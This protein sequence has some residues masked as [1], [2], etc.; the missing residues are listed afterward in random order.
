MGNK[1]FGIIIAI[2]IGAVIALLVFGGTSE[3]PSNNESE[4]D[5]L[6]IT[7]S[8]HVKNNNREGQVTIIEYADFQCPACAQYYPIVEQVLSQYQDDQ[9][10]FAFRHF[11]LVN[12]H[13]NAM[14]AHRAAEAAGEQDKF[15]EMYDLLF[16]R[17]TQWSEASN[18]Q[19][20]IDG[21]AQE[22]EL[23]MDRYSAT[24]NSSDTLSFINSQLDA[25]QS[26]GVAS[27]PTF[28]VDGE[29]LEQNPRSVEEFTALID[30][31]LAE[32]SSDNT[33]N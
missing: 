1:T 13:P 9:V 25:G 22:L 12:I 23:D 26:I 16:Q 30:Q 7:E 4:G 11:P 3:A 32:D 2:I 27:T 19:E 8:D 15:F 20:V 14:V 24:F 6:A 21:Y 29:Q 28:F 33:E 10:T 31:A 5:V 18:A 17:Q